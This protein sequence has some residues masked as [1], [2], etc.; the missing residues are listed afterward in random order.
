MHQLDCMT[1][2]EEKITSWILMERAA[3][4]LALGIKHLEK[5]AAPHYVVFCGGGNNGGDG[6]AIA[7]IFHSWGEDVDCYAVRGFSHYSDDNITNYMSLKPAGVL[8]NINSEEDIP[9]LNPND[10]IIDA[11]FGSGLNRPLSGL[12]AKVVT[13]INSAKSHID[14]VISIDTPSG[15]SDCN[16]PAD[17]DVVVMADYTFTIEI[18]FISML[19][20][21]NARYTGI[22]KTVNIGLC[23]NKLDEFTSNYSLTLQDTVFPMLRRREKFSHKGTFGHTL[24]VCGQYGKAGAAVLC[25]KACHRAG[26]GLLTTHV[27]SR[28]VDIMQISSPETMISVDPNDNA[29]SSKPSLDRFSAIGIGPGL[30]TSDITASALADIIAE[31]RVPMVLDADAL[32]I[33]SLNRELIERL[34]KDTILTPH[35]KEFERLFGS[36]ANSI[37]RL[38]AL[39]QNAQK[40]GIIIVLKGANTA[41]ALPDGNICF[42]TTGNPGMATAGS[43]DVLTGIVAALL[44]QKYSPAQAAIMGVYLHGMAGDIVAERIGCQGFLASDIVEA[45]PLAIKKLM[46]E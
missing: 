14:S 9:Q 1:I 30:G 40:Y 18:P 36:T 37:E 24:L 28:L 10:I 23:L 5:S 15:L 20:P 32:N 41:V 46:A 17:G 2:E 34:P 25:S 35:P 27:P 6:L 26:T 33:L 8:H 4:K 22:V 12:S 13:A 19:I 7:R 45:V 31:S 29:V 44:S 21:E 38:D 16:I 43:G 39:R 11:L 3:N 42:N